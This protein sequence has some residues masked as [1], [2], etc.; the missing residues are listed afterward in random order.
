MA[1]SLVGSASGS[2]ASAADVSVTLPGGVVQND[3]VYAAYAVVAAN[4]DN[5]C[6]PITAG[7][8]ELAD[9][10]GRD[11]RDCDFGAYRK[12]QGSTPDSTAQFD[13]TLTNSGASVAVL[14]V[15]RGVDTTTPEDATTT[16]ATGANSGLADPP[17]IT[18]VT[19]NA[20]VL[21][22]GA[23]TVALQATT[24]PTGYSNLISK[25]NAAQVS[26]ALASITKTPAGA[27]NPGNYSQ[28]TGTTSDSWCAC[29][30]AVRPFVTPASLPPRGAGPVHQHMLIRK[31]A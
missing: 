18:T 14:D 22:F 23:T 21:A 25:N 5:N 9:L 20:W 12:V 10:F 11:S 16:T 4:T 8:T 2:A 15:L 27:E 17:A 30:V 7:Y 3:V 19:D 28:W 31:A 6:V 29:T 1:I 13:S 26:I 24:P